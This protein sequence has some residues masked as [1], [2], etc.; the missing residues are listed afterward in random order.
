MEPIRT[1]SGKTAKA[2]LAELRQRRVVIGID[3]TEELA[4]KLDALADQAYA[5]VRAMR[6]QG[7]ALRLL[8]VDAKRT[9][10]ELRKGRKPDVELP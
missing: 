4:N 3:N 8:A 5:T 1:T 9:V 2:R 7:N 10:M 6:D